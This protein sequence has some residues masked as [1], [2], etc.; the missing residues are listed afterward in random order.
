[1]TTNFKRS[2]PT[3]KGFS[4]VELIIYIAILSIVVSSLTLTG[5]SLMSTFAHVQAR[6]DIA[7]TAS[8]AL[9]H[10]IREI[11]FAHDVDTALST[12]LVHPGVLVLNT[13]DDVGT[14]TT[15]SFSLSNGRI[16]MSEDG[17]DLT[18]LT[19][20]SV[21][22]TNLVFTRVLGTNTQAIRIEFTAERPVRDSTLTKAFQ[23]F[24]V[25]DG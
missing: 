23:T 13:S 16:V 17:G 15:A 11:R 14:E 24:I 10:M 9:E 1:M 5:L 3:T 20:S 18:P 19:R 21:T 25:L 22:I 6:A 8:I 2:T 4:L 12:L 7:E